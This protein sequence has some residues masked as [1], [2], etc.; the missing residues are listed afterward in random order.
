MNYPNLVEDS[1]DN[2]ITSVIEEETTVDATVGYVAN[3]ATGRD[4]SE[5]TSQ[6]ILLVLSGV[7][8]FNNVIQHEAIRSHQKVK[9]TLTF[10][11]GDIHQIHS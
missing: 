4:V 2:Y 3:V 1:N 11:D 7:T 9:L 10:V 8:R 5:L 6:P